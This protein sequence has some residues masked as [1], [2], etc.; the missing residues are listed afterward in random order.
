MKNLIKSHILPCFGILL[1][2]LC[3]ACGVASY[4]VI[5]GMVSEAASVNNL[6]WSMALTDEYRSLSPS[7]KDGVFKADLWED[8]N[9]I[10]K[11]CELDASGR[12]LSEG[13][14]EED[15][16]DAV[17]KRFEDKGFS[18]VE[19]FEQGYAVAVKDEHAMI[20]DETGKSYFTAEY[21]DSIYHIKDTAYFIDAH[22]NTIFDAKTR[23]HTAV[24]GDIQFIG[25][26]PGGYYANLESGGYTFLTEDFKIREGGRVY[27]KFGVPAQ[28][29]WYVERKTGAGKSGQTEKIEK[30]YVDE[31]G[32]MV[33]SLPED[34]LYGFAF[35][36]DK[37]LVIRRRCVECY[38]IDGNLLFSIDAKFSQDDSFIAGL[39]SGS[40]TSYVTDAETG[41][42]YVEGF[43]E[44]EILRFESGYAPLLLKDPDSSEGKYGVIDKK[45]KIIV[46]PIFDSLSPAKGGFMA[47]EY[48][49][50]YG[51]LDVKEVI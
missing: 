48:Q 21:G 49:N 43:N 11:F 40:N 30:G 28:G 17:P 44:S 26:A 37:A 47:V 1:L 14:Y 33:V 38:D 5:H 12:R 18:Y 9:G 13:I 42:T 16:L 27:E 34:T 50:K 3:L 46:E 10:N 22:E 45:G 35:S 39:G 32:D 19:P 15:P 51:I 41:Y 4:L 31:D 36:E 8:D 25:S 7:D 29:L 2:L 20:I 6:P 24:D 23:K